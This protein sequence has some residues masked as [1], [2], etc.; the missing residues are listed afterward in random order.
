M[1][2]VQPLPGPGIREALPVWLPVGIMTTCS[3][4]GLPA[5]PPA[6]DARLLEMPTCW[7][8]PPVG[9]A[10]LLEMPACWR[11]PPAGPPAGDAHLGHAHL[12]EM[13][14]FAAI[15]SP[16][17]RTTPLTA[18]ALLLPN[19]ARVGR[20]LT[21]VTLAFVRIL[22]PSSVATSTRPCLT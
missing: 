11:C 4:V 10:R 17:S 3:P 1:G 8:C 16:P 14:T 6:G 18:C 15:S 5:G 19:W 7:R 2:P 9:H 22:T 13:T 20:A 21:P 12:L